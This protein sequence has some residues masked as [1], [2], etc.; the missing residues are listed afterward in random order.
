M[1]DY[2]SFRQ[3]LDAVLRTRDAR[4]V[5]AFLIEANQWSLDQPA[6]PE[7]AMWLMIAGTPALK[8]LHAEARQWLLQH[9]HTEAVDALFSRHQGKAEAKPGKPAGPGS[10]KARPKGQGRQSPKP[11]S[12][13]AKG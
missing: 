13:G 12:P 7:Y 3:R 2:A 1:T 8:D 9:G 10:Q 5:R 6:D 4:Q 11:R